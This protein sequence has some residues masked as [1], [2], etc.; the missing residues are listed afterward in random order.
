MSDSK[1]YI[2]TYSVSLSKDCVSNPMGNID[3][4]SQIFG[5]A[6]GRAVSDMTSYWS[7]EEAQKIIGNNTFAYIWN[8]Y[9]NHRKDLLSLA[10]GQA[11]GSGYSNR[12]RSLSRDFCM[13]FLKELYADIPV[14][15]K[16]DTNYNRARLAP[17]LD[18]S[19][20][21]LAELNK[22]SLVE[23][24][25]EV[26][27]IW[28]KVSMNSSRDE[29]LFDY[30]WSKVKREKGATDKKEQIIK[31]ALSKGALSD[32]LVSR[33][34]KSSPKRLKRVVVCGINEEM[35]TLNRQL[36][37]AED[38]YTDTPPEDIAFLK[39]KLAKLESR[40]MLF[41]GCTDYTV[42]ESLID[43]LSRDNLPWLMPSVSE[44]YWLGQRIS[45][46]IESEDSY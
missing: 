17:I 45:R 46:L 23:E 27:E 18:H 36:R 22:F 31:C 43:C 14:D 41:V 11:T 9:P 7:S 26:Y 19:F 2:D 34:A 12:I 21:Y 1:K 30:L 32:S 6:V 24:D 13:D 37:R 3:F 38:A 25:E 20:D 15:D 10:I 44:H 42:V 39:E 40:A 4:S 33:I 29:N 8:S 28:K 16:V 35:S 5:Y